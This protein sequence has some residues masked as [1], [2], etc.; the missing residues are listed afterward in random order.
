MVR[1]RVST[2]GGVGGEDIEL[3]RV[4]VPLLRLFVFRR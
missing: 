1:V 4:F 2:G 3:L